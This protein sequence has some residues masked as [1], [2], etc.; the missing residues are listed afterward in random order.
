VAKFQQNTSLLLKDIYAAS[1]KIGEAG[2]RIRYMKAAFIETP[3]A[4]EQLFG[5]LKSLET[6]LGNLRERLSGNP[7]KN[8]FNE[9]TVPSIMSRAGSV[10]YGHW[11]TRQTPTKTQQQNIQ[12]A[13]KD[14]MAFKTDM[15][16]YYNELMQYESK[17]QAAGAPYT[18]GRK[19]E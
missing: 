15:K 5:G 8:K 16:A 4:N 7:I 14:F 3:K 10:A 6:K 2:N 1:S 17:L 9:S 19:L 11:G 12:I 13:K 18:V